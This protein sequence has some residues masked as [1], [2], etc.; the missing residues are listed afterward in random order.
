MNPAAGVTLSADEQV[1]RIFAWR[2]GFNAMHLIDLGI[3]LGLFKALAGHPG[4]TVAELAAALGLHAPYVQVWCTTAYS[5]EL[6]E[7]DERDGFRLAPHVDGMLA[8]EAHPRYLG[9]YVRLGTEFATDDYRRAAVAFH[10]GAVT[11]YQGRSREFAQAVTQAIA[12][13]NV[14]V[15]RKI[16][17]GL[18][19]LAERLRAGGRLLEVGCGTGFM[20]LQLARAFPQARLTGV[21]IDPTG[22][23][24]ARAAVRAAGLDE[25]IDILEGDVGRVVPAASFDLVLMV[26]VLHEID[27]ALRA[28]VVAACARALV[29]GGWLVIVDE[30]YPSTL[31][32]ARQAPYRFALQTGLEELMWGNVVPTREEQERLLRGAGFDGPIE[33]SLFGEGF[34]LLVA[35]R[36]A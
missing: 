7:A 35:Q 21:D 25:S 32:Q 13:V 14:M 26:E 30:T 15:A 10:T 3:R 28:D 17:P 22:L 5:L 11:P 20:Q 1:A 29:P 23:D 36:A 24:A 4:Q 6:L 2:R 31:D 33:R 8:N 9:G 12:G 27:P 16:L 19:G 18:S 34:T